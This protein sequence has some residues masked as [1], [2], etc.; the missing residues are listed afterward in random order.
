[1]IVGKREQ[2]ENLNEYSITTEDYDKVYLYDWLYQDI[3]CSNLNIG[4]MY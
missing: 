4:Y 2:L 1:M 3:Y